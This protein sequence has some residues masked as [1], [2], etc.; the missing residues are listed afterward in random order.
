MWVP[1]RLFD[2]QRAMIV[3]CCKTKLVSNYQ[4]GKCRAFK[5]IV[6]GDEI[7]LYYFD[8]SSK[9]RYKVWL[10]M[11]EK[12]LTSVKHSPSVKKKMVV[13]FFAKWG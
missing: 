6:T 3:D 8:G 5:N 12:T 1:H 4:D 2:E 7:E 9:S 11:K 10:F 13:V